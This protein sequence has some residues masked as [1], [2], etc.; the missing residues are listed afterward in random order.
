M[1]PDDRPT[2]R[3]VLDLALPENA[4][5][6]TTVRGYLIALLHD[7]WREEDGF[8]GKR[9]FGNSGWQYDIYAPMGRAGWIV[10][11]L[12]EDGYV[13][14]FTAEEHRKAESLVLSAI[15]ALGEQH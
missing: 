11:T 9:P 7:L 10:M 15:H 4:S 12:D 1:P 2:P 6:A 3:Q 5:G 14:D 13:E 8:S